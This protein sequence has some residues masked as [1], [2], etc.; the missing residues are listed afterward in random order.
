MKKKLYDIQKIN[1]NSS[2]SKEDRPMVI[3]QNDGIIKNGL[4]SYATYID[5]NKEI[6]E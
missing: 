4:Q 1:I 6:I 2:D 5:D 3:V